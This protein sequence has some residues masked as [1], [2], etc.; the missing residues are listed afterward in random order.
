MKNKINEILMYAFGMVSVVLLIV[1]ILHIQSINEKEKLIE[2]QKA[3]IEQYETSL[4]KCV[5]TSQVLLDIS[6]A[7]ISGAGVEC[8]MKAKAYD[9]YAFTRL[10]EITRK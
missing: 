7:Y 5:E 9:S 10:S 6:S 3:A 1:M 8:Y 2:K 4:N